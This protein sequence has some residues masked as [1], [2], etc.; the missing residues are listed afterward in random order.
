MPCIAENEVGSYHLGS[1]LH[2]D[3]GMGCLWSAALTLR[4]MIIPSCKRGLS[5]R[6]SVVTHEQA[7]PG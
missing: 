6:E 3:S 4:L 5:L 1:Q 7:F 2:S